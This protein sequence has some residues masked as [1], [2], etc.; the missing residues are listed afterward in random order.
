MK[1]LPYILDGQGRF[2]HYNTKNFHYSA[3]LIA[4][5]VHLNMKWVP[6]QNHYIKFYL[7]RALIMVLFAVQFCTSLLKLCYIWYIYILHD[8]FTSKNSIIIC[9]YL[10]VDLFAYRYTKIYDLNSSQQFK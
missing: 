5:K 2:P 9:T 8:Q 10:R 7:K 6:C 1:N 4:K 3:T